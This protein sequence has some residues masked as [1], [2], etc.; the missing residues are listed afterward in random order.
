MV[1]QNEALYLKEWIEYH[2]LVGVEHFYLFNNSSTDNWQEILQPYIDEGIVEIKNCSD[3]KRQE[4]NWVSLQCALYRNIIL[5]K[6]NEVKWLLVIDADEYYVPLVD[7]TITKML[8]RYD[9]SRL[10]S[11]YTQW[12]TFGT[13]QVDSLEENELLTEK[14]WMNSGFEVFGKSIVRPDRIKRMQSPHKPLLKEHMR[15]AMVPVHIGQLNHYWARDERFAWS[16]KWA[17]RENWGMKKHDFQQKINNANQENMERYIPILRFV[18]RL[19]EN[20]GIAS[21]P[22]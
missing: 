9:N 11:V 17:R 14:L 4:T 3:I 22:E 16:V 12:V 7:D 5:T 6:K 21:N 15:A 1:F 8:E 18:S 10:A 2:K 13:S 19:K 20:M